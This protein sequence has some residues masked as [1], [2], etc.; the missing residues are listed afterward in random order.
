MARRR[1]GETDS[2]NTVNAP[3]WLVIRDR[4]S[5]VME[6]RALEARADL[7]AALKAHGSALAAE[8]WE[9]GD[10]RY[11]AQLLILLCGARERSSVRVDRLLRAV[12]RTGKP[13]RIPGQEIVADRDGCRRVSGS[14]PAKR[15]AGLRFRKA[16][17]DELKAMAERPPRGPVRC[18][19][20]VAP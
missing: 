8:G 4:V 2:L 10:R 20:G 11:P 1:R 19:G 9:L 18:T 15:K 7:R 12:Q 6:Y 5:R 14:M 17:L 3:R 16:V 13:R